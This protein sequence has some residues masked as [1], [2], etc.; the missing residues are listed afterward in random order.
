MD[1]AFNFEVKNGMVIMGFSTWGA[2]PSH[3]KTMYSSGPNEGDVL[4]IGDKI[5]VNIGLYNS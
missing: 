2:L 1:H 5:I 3:I 4:E